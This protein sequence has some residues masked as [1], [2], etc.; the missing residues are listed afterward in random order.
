MLTVWLGIH[1][2]VAFLFIFTKLC[3]YVLAAWSAMFCI[4]YTTY[5]YYAL[6]V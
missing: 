1:M 4:V 3:V 6:Q 5:P 2:F